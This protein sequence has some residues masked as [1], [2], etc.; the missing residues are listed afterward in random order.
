MLKYLIILLDKSSIPF[1]HYDRKDSDCG[2]IS[3]ENLKEAIKFGMKENLMIQFVYPDY[4]LPNEYLSIID[5]IDHINIKPFNQAGK[6]DVCV[7]NIS[8]VGEFIQQIKYG[9][10]VVRGTI[11]EFSRDINLFKKLIYNVGRVNMVLTSLTHIQN[12]EI[13]LYSKFLNEIVDYIVSETKRG[14]ILP[15][16]NILTDRLTLDKMNNCNAGSETITIGPNGKF[17]ICPG[18]YHDR[19]TDI[20]LNGLYL[21]IPN[22]R[23]YELD[24]A[25]ICRECDAFQCHRCIWI[26]KK[27]TNEVNT[28]GHNQCVISHIERNASRELLSKLRENGPFL[29]GISMPVLDYL[30]PFEKIINK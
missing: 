26:N 15:K 28:P 6:D 5:S 18:F 19:D 17:Y 22:K 3:V 21:T 11:C 20:E 9:T 2:L 8:D 29:K 27:R 7:I 1:C 23:L 13:S 30:D 16:L 24:N 14:R 10:V 12:R 4:D 25:P